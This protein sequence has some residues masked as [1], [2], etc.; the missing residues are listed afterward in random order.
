MGVIK[1]EYGSCANDNEA[2]FGACANIAEFV[3]SPAAAAVAAADD[4]RLWLFISIVDILCGGF[5]CF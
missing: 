1:A 4:S 2:A 5:D 3:F